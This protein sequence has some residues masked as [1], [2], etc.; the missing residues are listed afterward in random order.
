MRDKFQ[1][2]LIKLLIPVLFVT[3]ILP[4]TGTMTVQAATASI[5]EKNVNIKLVDTNAITVTA[6]KIYIARSHTNNGGL[7]IE[8]QIHNKLSQPIY[9]EMNANKINGKRTYIGQILSNT[10]NAYGV[11]HSYVRVNSGA[12][13]TR[14][15]NISP[16]AYS[17]LG[18]DHISTFS[19]YFNVYDTSKNII[20]QTSGTNHYVFNL[21]SE[22]ATQG[23]DEKAATI[24]MEIKADDKTDDGLTSGFFKANL[25]SISG[26]TAFFDIQNNTDK[27]LDATISTEGYSGDTEYLMAYILPGVASNSIHTDSIHTIFSSSPE[28]DIHST[29]IMKSVLGQGKVNL[30]LTL[31]EPGTDEIIASKTFS[32]VDLS[33][34]YDSSSSNSSSLYIDGSDI[35]YYG[36]NPTFQ[37]TSSMAGVITKNITWSSSN[38]NVAT[39]DKNGRIQ[40]KN[41]GTTM[42]S[43][44]YNG[45]NAVLAVEVRDP[46]FEI[47]TD[48]VELNTYSYFSYNLYPELD[49]DDPN[50]VITSSDSSILEVSGHYLKGKKVGTATVTA[51]YTSGT[52]KV[53]ETSRDIRVIPFTGINFYEEN[54]IIYISGDYTDSDS[55]IWY[56]IYSYGDSHVIDF[57]VSVS[58]PSVLS[59]TATHNKDSEIHVVPKKTGTADVTLSY[60]SHTKKI[61]FTVTNTNGTGNN[62]NV[63]ETVPTTTATHYNPISFNQTLYNNTDKGFSI[64]LQKSGYDN[65]GY[66]MEL[67]IENNSGITGSMSHQITSVNNIKF[68][69][70]SSVSSSYFPN[71]LITVGKGHTR[72]RVYISSAVFSLLRTTRVE[73]ISGNFF[74][75][76][77]MNESKKYQVSSGSPSSYVLDKKNYS[78][79]INENN[80][81]IRVV[82]IVEGSTTEDA[83]VMVYAKNT[84]STDSIV[85]DIFVDEINGT[86]VTENINWIIEESDM[87]ISPST[88]V[89]GSFKIPSTT[90]KKIGKKINSI[91]LDISTRAKNDDGTY[92]NKYDGS[93]IINT[94]NAKVTSNALH[95]S[96]PGSIYVGETSSQIAVFEADHDVLT[97]YELDPA[98]F[99]W[100]SSNTD[101]VVVSND[102]RLYPIAVGSAMITATDSKGERFGAITVEVKK[103][104]ISTSEELISLSEG[105]Y[106]DLRDFYTIHPNNAVKDENITITSS[107]TSVAKIVDNRYLVGKNYGRT[108]VTVKY[109]YDDGSILSKDMT[110]DVTPM[111]NI[112]LSTNYM[113]MHIDECSEN[114]YAMTDSDEYLYEAEWYVDDPSIVKIVPLSKS[115]IQV[116]DFSEI[117]G[118]TGAVEITPLSSGE[119]TI[120]A[121]YDGK[122]AECVIKVID[123]ND[124]VSDDEDDDIKEQP[125]DPSKSADST[126]KKPADSKDPAKSANPADPANNTPASDNSSAA[127]DSSA[128]P[129]AGQT[130]TDTR[131]GA[132]YVITNDGGVQF[133]SSNNPKATSVVIPD[134]VTINGVTYPVTSVSAG[135]FKNN[136]KITQIKVGK[137]VT[138]IESSAFAGAK[139]LKNVNLSNAKIEVIQKNAFKN[140][141][142]L[143]DIKLNG[144]ALK[145]VEKGAFKGLKKNVKVTVFAK[146]KKTFNKDVKKLEKAGLKTASFKFKKKKK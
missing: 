38:T 47:T 40:P 5:S 127:G 77:I 139:N 75:Y 108:T 97:K 90:Y 20:S 46:A 116:G 103:A 58:D 63:K 107:N 17:Q 15:A 101:Y 112:S 31:K 109:K 137:N 52:G 92:T 91:K 65:K 89:L 56:N 141:S 73:E 121:Y 146:D 145:K 61:H 1:K 119:T 33:K 30:T 124:D 45:Q 120:Y 59:V 140:C 32:N 71:Q 131:T 106:R 110:F 55:G 104:E 60:G 99:N 36:E 113:S 74:F 67:D 27:N 25:V 10:S 88:E 4:G 100:E 84:S 105:S 43:A 138:K 69:K 128:A 28:V 132:S 126:D 76:E 19:G 114:L 129:A 51:K 115:Q 130:I 134:T 79:V 57:N 122:T 18:I 62:S 29:H 13:I 82:E 24:S 81:D 102:G 142:K 87:L 83:S 44:K 117:P 7:N 35:V 9:M 42:I 2:L 37:L 54:P 11:N 48:Y 64:K 3:F 16:S 49:E 93:K 144:N 86:P 68:P 96:H 53:Y 98:D 95:L 136:K 41:P 34:A 123:D 14:S 23:L 133:T 125:A 8:L 50:L 118:Y 22:T 70:Y 94:L 111:N 21:D 85:A 72:T 78:S 12:T 80:I 6:K 135:A 66:F 143:S 39:I 26:L